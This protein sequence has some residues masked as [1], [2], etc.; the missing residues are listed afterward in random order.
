MLVVMVDD[1]ALLLPSFIV[2]DLVL[3]LNSLQF[4]FVALLS[5]FLP[6][7]QQEYEWPDMVSRVNH[8]LVT[9]LAIDEDEIMVQVPEQGLGNPY[10]QYAADDGDDEKSQR[11]KSS[12]KKGSGSSSSS[13]RRPSSGKK[14]R[15]GTAGR[16]RAERD[17][18]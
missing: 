3:I 5:P 4:P 14:E 18:V 9:N 12:S 8:V 16:R 13:T 17:D 11:R 1:R 6:P 7:A 10:Q 15:P 2:S